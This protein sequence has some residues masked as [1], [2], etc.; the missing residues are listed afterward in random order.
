MMRRVFLDAN[1]LVPY[2]LASLF[3]AL[4]EQGACEVR[5]SAAVL[6][7]VRRTLINK[8]HLSEAKADRRLRA[9][10]AGFPEASVAADPDGAFRDL[11]CD[12]KDHHVLD[13][14]ISGGATHLVTVNLRDFGT[15]SAAR[16][17]ITVLHPD[18]FLLEMLACDKMA[19]RRAVAME[20]AQRTQSSESA[21]DFLNALIKLAPRTADQLHEDAA[22]LDCLAGWYRK[23][24]VPISQLA[25]QHSIT[26]WLHSRADDGVKVAA[27]FVDPQL[28]PNGEFTI[29]WE[30]SS[31]LNGP[32][33]LELNA[34]E[35]LAALAS[36]PLS[37]NNEEGR[38]LRQHVTSVTVLGD[39]E[40]VG[41][42]TSQAAYSRGTGLPMD[43]LPET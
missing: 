42:V 23:P 36:V 38:Q 19:A 29:R 2:N 35:N 27:G 37:F 8:L 21:A 25:A 22:E 1:V 4:A 7:E 41:K 30:G 17:G 5:W 43:W 39:S 6:T 9:M 16:F 28:T 31:T 3:L 34:H 40:W 26:E 33:L 24:E 14:A 15:E 13:A 20:L 11:D 32:L 10:Q 12:P 18:E